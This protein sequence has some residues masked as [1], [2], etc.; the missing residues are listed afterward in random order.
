MQKIGRIYRGLL[1][2]VG[3]FMLGMVGFSSLALHASQEAPESEPPVSA[4]QLPSPAV[5]ASADQSNQGIFGIQ[6]YGDSREGSTYYNALT[7]L[8]PQW[9][10]VT[11]YWGN[12]E[13][14]RGIYDWSGADR[15]VGYAVT[16]PDVKIILTI[17]FAPEW[18]VQNS[19]IGTGGPIDEE[20]LDDFA[21]WVEA[22]VERYNGDGVNDAPGSP[23]ID[24][25]EVYNEPDRFCNGG[26]GWGNNGKEY[27]E[28]LKI[29]H[30]SAKKANP[31]IQI[32]M[33]GIAYDWFNAVVD[34]Q[35]NCD[36]TGIEDFFFT[37]PT[38]FVIDF[39]DTV[40][41]NGGGDYF[42]WMAFHVYPQFAKNWTNSPNPDIS[43]ALQTNQLSI[44]VLEKTMHIRE[45]LAQYGY[46]NKPIAITEVG[47]TADPT[48]GPYPIYPDS[49]NQK[50]AEHVVAIGAQALAAGVSAMIWWPLF[51]IPT[52]GHENDGLVTPNDTSR[53]PSFAVYQN[54]IDELGNAKPV[55]N[56]R[57]TT[58]YANRL[59]P[60]WLG[61]NDLDTYF[62]SDTF[63]VEAYKFADPDRNRYVYVAWQNPLFMIRE[64]LQ[65]PMVTF[66]TVPLT[67]WA[68]RATVKDTYGNTIQ[69]V[70]DTNG[71]NRIQ[72]M[73]G[74]EPVYIIVA[75]ADN[76]EALFLP[77]LSR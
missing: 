74:N 50:Q 75:K 76:V 77:S 40:L 13:R 7:D 39:L 60:W 8:G 63:T 28:L 61:Y 71:D 73:L 4:Q 52:L 10:R 16:N 64:N 37:A 26:N 49:G 41:A 67:I 19:N 45:K 27:A 23:V 65:A 43:K 46:Y 69:T 58:G 35:G 21:A 68:K 51:D 47:A 29:V 2:F 36:H 42:D 30:E 15:I 17:D 9:L 72:I 11:V 66:A 1:L 70:T 32:M 5:A 6:M 48:V 12:V 34:E 38:P 54:L 56:L 25:I 55:S 33:G 57:N 44:G 22:I 24:F 18:A 3:L 20:A 31:N 59:S 53:R 14:T 62:T